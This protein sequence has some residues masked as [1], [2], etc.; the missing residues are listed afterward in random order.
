ML[1]VIVY[2]HLHSKE[3]KHIKSALLDGDTLVANEIV[4]NLIKKG[5]EWMNDKSVDVKNIKWIPLSNSNEH[6]ELVGKIEVDSNVN[7]FQKYSQ[8]VIEWLHYGFKIY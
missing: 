2:K 8:N 6:I 3:K 7:G 1:N 5:N 4:K